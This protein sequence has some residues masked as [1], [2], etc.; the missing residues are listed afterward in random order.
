MTM[1]IISNEEAKGRPGGRPFF[2]PS[3]AGVTTGRPVAGTAQAATW[4]S[5]GCRRSATWAR[6]TS[7]PVRVA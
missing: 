2:V 3:A 6:S 7:C 5:A 1:P 4:A